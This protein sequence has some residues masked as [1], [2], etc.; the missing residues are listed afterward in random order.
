MD[1]LKAVLSSQSFGLVL[2]KLNLN[3]KRRWHKNKQKKKTEPRLISE[4]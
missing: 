4:L 1:H 3:N 2:T